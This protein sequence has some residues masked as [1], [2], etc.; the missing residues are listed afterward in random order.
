MFFD[1]CTRKAGFADWSVERMAKN[2]YIV[3][4]IHFGFVGTIFNAV[5]LT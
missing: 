4:G 5:Q 2:R 3:L 1:K